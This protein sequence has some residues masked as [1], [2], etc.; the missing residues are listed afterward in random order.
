MASTTP[1]LN[2][3]FADA[4]KQALASL[5]QAQELSLRAVEAAVGAVPAVEPWPGF[6]N[7]LPNTTELVE[8]TFGFAGKVLDSQKAYA[9]RLAE[10]V[11]RAAQK[12]TD[13]AKKTA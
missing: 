10:I 13:G 11:T 5:E 9:V 6:S 2:E 3:I 8:S 1:N 4:Q 12:S 7:T